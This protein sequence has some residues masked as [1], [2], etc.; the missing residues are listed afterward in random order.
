ME[1]AHFTDMINGATNELPPRLSRKAQIEAILTRFGLTA[2]GDIARAWLRF[3][4]HM[5]R[6][7]G[8][9]L[10]PSL[11]VDAEFGADSR[12]LSTPSCVD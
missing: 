1:L 11:A 6:Q 4:K 2:D 10:Y 9:A 8:R 3:G 12:S 5:A 7:H